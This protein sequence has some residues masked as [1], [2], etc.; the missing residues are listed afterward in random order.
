MN[1]MSLA[2]ALGEARRRGIMKRPA[3][4]LLTL[5]LVGVLSARAGQPAPVPAT[6]YQPVGGPATEERPVVQCQR[7]FPGKSASVQL[8][9]P[10]GQVDQVSV[11][12]TAPVVQP[13]EPAVSFK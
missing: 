3:G 4:F 13:A 8:I 1:R 9:Q 5:L 12:G 10:A 6:V 7:F 2:F 11:E